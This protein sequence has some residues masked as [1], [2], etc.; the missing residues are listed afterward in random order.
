MSHTDRWRRISAELFNFPWLYRIGE[1]PVTAPTGTPKE[2]NLFAVTSAIDGAVRVLK[3]HGSLNWYSTH[4]SEKLSPQAMFKPTRSLSITRRRL[5]SPTMGYAGGKR[6]TYTL[7]VVVPP[8]THKS[9]VLHRDMQPVWSEAEQAIREADEVV[10]FGY[11]C[12]SL[13]FESSNQL[14]RAQRKQRARVSVIDPNGAIAARYI[15]LLTP[16]RLSYYPS[17]AA[18]LA[19]R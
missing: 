1:H 3:L 12:P 18:F 7:P 17:A 2:E 11:S 9:A 4:N 6:R 19:G 15:E 13:D 8:V 16:Q 5:I 14:R 10:I